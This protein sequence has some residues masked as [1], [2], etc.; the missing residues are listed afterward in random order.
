MAS[1]SKRFRVTCRGEIDGAALT[2]LQ[3]MGLNVTPG[4]SGGTVAF[5]GG[6]IPG[7]PVRYRFFD[8]EASDEDAARKQVAEAVKKVGASCSRYDVEIASKP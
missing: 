6:E 1:E 5:E 2:E 7:K 4:G 8:I 3:G